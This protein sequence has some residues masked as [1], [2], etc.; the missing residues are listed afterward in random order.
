MFLGK[1][2]KS[3]LGW[4]FFYGICSWV[5]ASGV[6]N[7]LPTPAVWA[8]ILSQTFLGFLIGIVRWNIPWWIRGLVL[9]AAVNLPLGGLLWAVPFAWGR[10]LCVP[11]AL[12]GILFGLLIELGV[13]HS[14]KTTP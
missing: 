5:L 7:K 4:G 3:A 11:F 13:R 6:T 1:R 9:G 14:S 12:S 8:I 2:I 10:G